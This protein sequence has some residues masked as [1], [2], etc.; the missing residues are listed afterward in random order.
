MH[1]SNLNNIFYSEPSQLKPLL[2]QYIS[3]DLLSTMVVLD[4]ASSGSSSSESACILLDLATKR[5]PSHLKSTIN[6]KSEEYSSDAGGYAGQG[7]PKIGP[8]SKLKGVHKILQMLSSL[9]VLH[10]QQAS[11]KATV[12]LGPKGLNGFLNT[13]VVPL[14]PEAYKIFMSEV[15]EIYETLC[16][17][18]NALAESK[19]NLKSGDSQ[20]PVVRIAF[21]HLTSLFEK[22]TLCSNLMNYIVR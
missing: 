20:R 6:P 4:L 16:K 1:C 9:L 22:K 2:D 14:E 17:A 10:S 7:S 11:D 19:S 15:K 21:K 3:E 12:C 5:L 13:G 18:S 8:A